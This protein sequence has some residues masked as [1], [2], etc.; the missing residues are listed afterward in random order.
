MYVHVP[1][2]CFV[3]LC[4]MFYQYFVMFFNSCL[5]WYLSFNFQIKRTIPTPP[6]PRPPYQ[7][8]QMNPPLD[9]GP[10]KC[11]RRRVQ[12][13]GSEGIA[14]SWQVQHM[15]VQIMGRGAHA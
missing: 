10:L 9:L 15:D 8:S 12:D 11:R 14:D 4:F 2:F 5:R 13:D 7:R 3:F 6:F 1:F